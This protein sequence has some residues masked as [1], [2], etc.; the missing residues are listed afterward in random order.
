MRIFNT[1]NI[2]RYKNN[3]YCKVKI[4]TVNVSFKYKTKSLILV[5]EN[6]PYM[7]GDS[8]CLFE[9]DNKKI[10]ETCKFTYYSGEE[11]HLVNKLV[12]YGISSE[13]Y[14]LCD[15]GIIND[16]NVLLIKVNKVFGLYFIAEENGNVIFESIF[17]DFNKV[18]T[19]FEKWFYD[20]KEKYFI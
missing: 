18:E 12:P 16:F 6:E 9:T 5:L 4:K 20:F 17:K 11:E 15:T 19:K 10:T 1:N 8:I 2:I 14:N 7:L 13:I 3:Y